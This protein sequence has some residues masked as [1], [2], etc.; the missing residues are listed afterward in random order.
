MLVC[1]FQAIDHTNGLPIN[2]FMKKTSSRPSQVIILVLL[3]LCLVNLVALSIILHPGGTV[4]SRSE[5][6]GTASPTV[7]PS[8]SITSSATL[9]I[10]TLEPTSTNSP[11]PT[12]ELSAL[13][14]LIANGV[15]FFSMAEGWNTHLFAYHP[16]FLP[17]TRLTNGNWDDITPVLSPD[18]RHLAFSSKANGYWDLFLM[19]LE[20]GDLTRL[21]DTGAFD[22]HPTWSPDGQWLAYESYVKDHFEIKLLSITN[23]AETP[24]SLT[25]GPE[26]SH[27]PAWSPLG[28]EIAFVSNRSGEDEIWV[29]ALDQVENR[30]ANLSNSQDYPQSAPKWSM[31]GSRLAWV[32]TSQTSQSIVIYDRNNSQAEYLFLSTGNDPVWS[33]DGHSILAVV[34]FPNQN[35]L[36]VYDSA[37]G[38]I[39]QPVQLLPGTI[40]G[41]DWE[42]NLNETVVAHLLQLHATQLDSEGI[43]K[44]LLTVSPAPPSGRMGVV[45]L[46]DVQTNYAYLSDAVDEAF[47]GLRSLAARESGWDIL[48]TLENAYLPLT[49]PPQPGETEDW[50]FTGR[51][52]AISSAPM[53]AGWMVIQREDYAGQ[54]YWRVFIRARYQDGSQGSPLPT[55]IWDLSDRYSGDPQAYE[56]GGAIAVAPG[57]YWVDF[58]EL[59]LRFGWERLAAQMNWRTY[60]PA[61][62]FN[63]FV[64]TGGLSWSAA[65]EQIYPPEALQTPTGVSPLVPTATATPRWGV[66]R[67]PT[68]ASEPTRRPTWTP[69][70]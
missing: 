63:Q 13:E 7:Q 12:V 49:S 33:P 31:D 5:V 65:M 61:T 66:I 37:T 24:I 9:E 62:R 19:D 28:R 70:P 4:A 10:A 60:F 44:P 50:L 64:I 8:P 45:P 46:N 47:V 32:N 18:G 39:Q 36:V 27:S 67:S 2:K 22:G 43:T 54:T 38:S 34:P 41:I 1:A 14:G 6:T 69:S 53:T 26:S 16:Q 35:G 56:Q 11:E 68:S 30:F 21:T 55:T 40:S 57:G 59:A 52:I 51:G 3:I 58:T 42:D 29:A 23:P 48:A 25:S 20:T 17:L 15:Y